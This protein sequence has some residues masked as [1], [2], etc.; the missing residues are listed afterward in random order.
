MV[1]WIGC[2]SRRLDNF[3]HHVDPSFHL[4]QMSQPAV[5]FL[6]VSHPLMTAFWSS[7]MRA[8]PFFLWSINISNKRYSFPLTS[9]RAY[10]DSA[11]ILVANSVISPNGNFTSQRGISKIGLLLDLPIGLPLA[12]CFWHIA[13][14][15][16]ILSPLGSS[17]SAFTY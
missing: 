4:Q 12:P 13:Q 10:V 1:T 5:D 2:N 9:H 11:M 16:A 6:R 17:I 8:E 3:S 7:T 15:L 14:P